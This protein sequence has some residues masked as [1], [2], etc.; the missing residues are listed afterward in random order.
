MGGS[1]ISQPPGEGHPGKGAFLAPARI[2]PRG[3]FTYFTATRG[4]APLSARAYTAP[5]IEMMKSL[6][7]EKLFPHLDSNSR[8][9][10]PETSLLRLHQLNLFTIVGNVVFKLRFIG[11]FWCFFSSLTYGREYRQVTH[12]FKGNLMGNPNLDSEIE[13]NILF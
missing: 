7:P 9:T 6:D 3:W 11:F 5:R 10:D 1:H 4:R 12:H 13:K 8:S 2:R